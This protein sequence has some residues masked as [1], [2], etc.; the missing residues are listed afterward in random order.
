MAAVTP[1]ICHAAGRRELAALYRSFRSSF[2]RRQPLW[3]RMAPPLPLWFRLALKRVDSRLTLQY[4]PPKSKDR[5]GCPEQSYPEGV[6]CVC[7]KL[8]RNPD[9][10]SKRAVFALADP[11]GRPLAPTRRLLRLLRVARNDRRQR[12]IDRL[13]RATE[14]AIEAIGCRREAA[15]K[16]IL[17]ER[18]ENNLRTLQGS[19]SGR[20]WIFLPART[21]VPA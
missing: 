10:V 6:W 18:I 8:R 3:N 2:M 15:S 16:E 20:P 1:G 5:R 13:E 19:A 7:A 12:G 14:G 11:Q 4:I 9:W 21:K 17:L